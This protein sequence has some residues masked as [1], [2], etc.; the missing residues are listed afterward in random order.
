MPVFSHACLAL[1]LMSRV[2]V[3]VWIWQPK[4]TAGDLLVMF[5]NE[6]VHELRPRDWVREAVTPLN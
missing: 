1:V 5:N 4:G 6:H 3:C 2:C